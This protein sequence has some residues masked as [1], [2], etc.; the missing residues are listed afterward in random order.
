MALDSMVS[1]CSLGSTHE[2]LYGIAQVKVDH[3]QL[4]CDAVKEHEPA[5]VSPLIS[6]RGSSIFECLRWADWEWRGLQ[7]GF[8]M[9]G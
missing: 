5:V 3:I 8:C 4:S 2:A 7:L 6:A 9:S 1:G